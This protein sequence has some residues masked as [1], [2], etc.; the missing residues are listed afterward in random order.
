M[1]QNIKDW[2]LQE[3]LSAGYFFLLLLGIVTESV[4][5]RIIGINVLQYAGLSDILI[6]PVSLLTANPILIIILLFII[7]V[8]YLLMKR[9]VPKMGSRKQVERDVEV[10]NARLLM[11]MANFVLFL[12]IGIEIGR[13]FKLKEII[14]EGK[15]RPDFLVKFADSGEQ[16]VKVVGQNASYL[17][18]V[19]EGGKQVIIRPIGGNVLQMQKLANQ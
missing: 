14:A 19:P 2:G 9:L 5:Y 13:G 12:F 15:T 3:Y 7:G 8:T 4:F 6:S 17:F 18:Y 10:S 1:N 16:R 11:L